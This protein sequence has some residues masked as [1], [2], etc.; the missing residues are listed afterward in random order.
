MLKNISSELEDFRYMKADEVLEFSDIQN[1]A[2]YNLERLQC[3]FQDPRGVEFFG[4]GL[5]RVLFGIL[6][7]FGHILNTFKTNVFRSYRTLKRTELV[8]YVE[9]NKF[10][11]MRLVNLDYDMVKHISIPVPD[12][13]SEPY[14]QTT[15]YGSDLLLVMQMKETTDRFVKGLESLRNQVLAMT[16]TLEDLDLPS[17]LPAVTSKFKQFNRCFVGQHLR[18]IQMSKV[19]KSKEELQGTYE[20]LLDSAKY[21]Y[22]VA[23]V[24]KNMETCSALLTEIINF[25]E[26]DGVSISKQQLTTLSELSLYYAK[27]FDMYGVTIQ[28]MGRVE[29]NFVEVLKLVRKYLNV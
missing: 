26:K 17:N 18:D 2:E 8:Y 14:L 29:H 20:L 15:Q 11:T 12:K 23:S 24:V 28:D 6:N 1:F 19:I 21:H 5:T 13:M 27:M 7:T 4:S 9:S 25:I 16:V 10:T 22:E 3:L